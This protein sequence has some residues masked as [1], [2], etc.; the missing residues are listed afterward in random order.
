MVSDGEYV[1]ANRQMEPMAAD[2]VDDGHECQY[3]SDCDNEADWLVEA[4]VGVGRVSFFCCAECSRIHAIW[5]EE[6]E[7]TKTDI[8]EELKP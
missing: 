7:L 6:N 3:K 2:E 1:A 4:A 5:V 8:S